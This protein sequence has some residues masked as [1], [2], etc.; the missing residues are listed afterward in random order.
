MAGITSLGG[1][2]GHPYERGFVI[3]TADAKG[4]I[5]DVHDRRPI[6]FTAA[7]LARSVTLGADQFAWYEVNK[8]V[9]NVRNEGPELAQPLPQLGLLL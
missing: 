9:G 7:E 1:P 3:V 4:G 8:A 2:K 6:V 5:V